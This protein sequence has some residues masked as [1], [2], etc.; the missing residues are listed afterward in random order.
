[1]A[2]TKRSDHESLARQRATMELTALIRANT[3][4]TPR[5]I[6]ETTWMSG[7]SFN[8]SSPGLRWRRY[9]SGARSMS[10]PELDRLA[11]FALINGWVHL[12]SESVNLKAFF[13]LGTLRNLYRQVQKG[14]ELTLEL[15]DSDKDAWLAWYEKK[16]HHQIRAST[17]VKTLSN[18][19]VAATHKLMK[20]IDKSVLQGGAYDFW[21]V[22]LPDHDIECDVEGN[23]AVL[24]S[25]EQFRQLVKQVQHL[26]TTVQL[27][28]MHQFAADWVPEAGG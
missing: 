18:A 13:G 19:V 26:A 1:M 8:R 22:D 21:T 24:T 5:E 9:E 11:R 20:E 28:S 16:R 17:R 12:D 2:R 14:H 10:L 7:S 6:E 25:A 15:I 23:L 3:G 27:E 4:L